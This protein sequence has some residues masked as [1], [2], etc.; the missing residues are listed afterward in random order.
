MV[1]RIALLL[2]RTVW[3]RDAGGWRHESFESGAGPAPCAVRR[4]AEIL[5]E[6]TRERTIVVF[7]PEG[8]VHQTVETPKVKRAVFATLARVRDEHP[9]VSSEN[10]GWGVEYPEPGPG[11]T[12]VTLLHSEL[13][14]GLVHLRDACARA[15]SQL[16]AAWSAYTAAAACLK[17]RTFAPRVRFVLVLIPDFT[18]IVAC[19]G[20][21]RSFRGWAGPMSERDWKAFSVLIGD[22]EARTSPSMADV[23]LRRGSITV[24]AEGAPD[25]ICPVWGDLHSAG[26]IEAVLDLDSFATSAARI[27][28][29]HPANL[30][31]AF[32][33]PLDLNRQILAAGIAGIS[34]GLALGALAIGGRSQATAE[35]KAGRVRVA[36][37]E[38]RLKGLRENEREMAR[39][40]SKAPDIHGS[41]HIVGH[42]A[43][44]G[45]AAAI[46]DALTLTSL[47]IR[48]DGNF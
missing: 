39:L 16:R 18:A 34:V 19:G 14:P 8:I 3:T 5:S 47:A 31:D 36:N 27:Q 29:A 17:S 20:G 9:V 12:F 35:D 24:I 13:T 26:R 44:V 43:L 37:I 28:T 7:E 32:P 38:E 42:D 11:G 33:V 30:V 40:R 45:L 23:G 15:G 4:L 10:L 25:R 48:R 21:K 46:P 1:P 41:L 2:G 22:S 6:A